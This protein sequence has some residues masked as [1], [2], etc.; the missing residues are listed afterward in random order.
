MFVV[1]HSSLIFAE[2]ETSFQINCVSA[3]SKYNVSGMNFNIM[4]MT[5]RFYEK[6]VGFIVLVFFVCCNSLTHGQASKV[7]IALTQFENVSIY[8]HILKS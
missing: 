2:K 5:I 7:G 3:F 8:S 4:T 1:T 6:S